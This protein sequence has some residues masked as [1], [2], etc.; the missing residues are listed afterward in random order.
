ME[1]LQG[2]MGNGLKVTSFFYHYR[3]KVTPL[4]YISILPTTTILLMNII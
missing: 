4:L 1:P 2:L 3:K